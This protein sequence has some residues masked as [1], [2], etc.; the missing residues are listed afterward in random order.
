M[1]SLLGRTAAA[2]LVM[3]VLGICATA[4]GPEREVVILSPDADAILRG[5]IPLSADVRPAGLQ[6]SQVVFYVDGERVCA[7]A[8]RPYH[9]EFDAGAG[10]TQRVIRVV[11]ELGGGDRLTKSVR[12]SAMP[13]ATFRGAVDL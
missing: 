6:V 10:L 9:C 1:T 5:K 12:T 13:T 11:A 8:A 4:Q 2:A 3:A 7:V